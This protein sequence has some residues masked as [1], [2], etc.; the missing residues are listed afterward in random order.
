MSLRV[1]LLDSHF[2][3]E[4]PPTLLAE[5]AAVVPAG[6]PDLAAL[7]INLGGDDLTAALTLLNMT[8]LAQCRSFAVHAGV[9]SGPAGVIAL[10]AV[11]G[12]GKSTLVAACLRAGLGYIS[13]E[14]LVVDWDTGEVQPYPK[15]LSLSPWSATHVGLV[16]GD[17]ERA[18]PAT[19]LGTLAGPTRLA[20][21]VLPVRRP[22]PATLQP[23]SRAA[24]AHRLLEM[25]FNHYQRPQRAFALVA[26]L[27]EAAQAWQ[28]GYAEATEGAR[29]LAA[30]LGDSAD[31]TAARGTA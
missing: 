22:G 10:P 23:A 19:L 7:E 26:D 30:H 18:Y 29:L 14:A 4:G 11:S 24:A 28:L 8:A 25:S 20:H 17:D 27:L 12:A 2:L 21:V 16:A 13:D 1:D 31:I 6:A 3:L 9:V 15:W 5:I